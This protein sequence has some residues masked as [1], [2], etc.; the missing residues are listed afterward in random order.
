MRTSYWLTFLLA[1][2]FLY[3]ACTQ[4][5]EPPPSNRDGVSNG[6][7]P[8]TTGGL[9]EIG[10]EKPVGDRAEPEPDR[11][12]P[13]YVPPAERS[14]LGESEYT[15]VVGSFERAEQADQ[16]SFELRTAR[17]NNFV[18][19]AN[20][21]WHVCV[22]QYRSRGLA[23]NMLARVRDKGYYNAEIASPGHNSK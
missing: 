7:E 21:K 13:E 20:G 3:G 9:E 1:A 12:D 18:D 11:N 17:I 6:T 16:L 5:T 2:V 15:V 8:E 22:G 10:R 14:K 23:K 19:R 4:R